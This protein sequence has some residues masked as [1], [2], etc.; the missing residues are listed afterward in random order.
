MTIELDEET[1]RLIER[2]VGAGHFTD[3]AA[4]LGC[5]VKHFV[6][7]RQ[8]L[9]YGTDY[10]KDQVETMISGAIASRE[11]GEGMDGDEFFAQLEEEA[12]LRR[13]SA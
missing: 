8:D 10:D 9:G 12:E 4:F 5:T 1:Q 2:E 6:A 7:L 13:R 3:A 11:R